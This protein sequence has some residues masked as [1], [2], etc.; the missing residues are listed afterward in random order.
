MT[1]KEVKAF[2][3]DP[4]NSYKCYGCPYN[5]GFEAGPNGNILPC[6]QYHCWV[7]LHNKEGMTWQK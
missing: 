1:I 3:M 4:N 6:G 7:D 2:L 5:D